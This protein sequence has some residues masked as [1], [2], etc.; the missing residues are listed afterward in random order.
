MLAP[1]YFRGATIIIASFSIDSHES[2]EQLQKTWIPPMFSNTNDCPIFMVGLKSDLEGERKVTS[3]E[4]INFAVS[5]GLLY[6]EAS[7]KLNVGVSEFFRFCSLC[8]FKKS[9]KFHEIKNM[10]TV[11]SPQNKEDNGGNSKTNYFC[12]IF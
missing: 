5:K 2:F 4:A 11:N 7:S 1:M 10:S 3:N 8:A 6:F 12:F 9:S